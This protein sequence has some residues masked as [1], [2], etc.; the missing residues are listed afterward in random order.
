MRSLTRFFSQSD[1]LSRAYRNIAFIAVA[2][3]TAAALLAVAC[4]D[5]DNSGEATA[6]SAPATAATTSFLSGSLS[7]FAAA[8]LTD[9]FNEAK[10]AFTADNPDT[11]IEF[12]FAG[13]AAL[14]TQLQEGAPADVLA[15]AA[16]SNMETALTNG[17]VVD[18]GHVFARN[19][20]AVIVPA[21]NPA[22][23]QSPCE[24]ANSGVKLVVAEEGV[25][26]GDYGREA[27]VNLS[28]D[29]ACG[30]GFSDAALANVMSNEPNVK[31]VVTKVQLGEADAGI[32]YVTDVTP[33]VEAD[34]MI[35]PIEDAYNVI[36]T[37]PI[38]VTTSAGDAD[39]ATAFID[40]ILSADGQA[41][42]E[43]YGFLPP[44]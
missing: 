19:V 37:Y 27:F 13:S 39:L 11:S 5:D 35:I 41:I 7:V 36:A 32:A 6:T 38:A 33:D 9:A 40:F 34:I 14:V 2:L 16:T 30:T 3:L 24:L 18:T 44:Q 12:N 10:D 1:M 8:S 25:P 23:I 22:N 28:V 20:L 31:A 21:D 43:S 26:A 15:T 42:L 29:A 17:S 4:G